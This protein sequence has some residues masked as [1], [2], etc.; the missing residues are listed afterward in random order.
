MQLFFHGVSLFGLAAI[1][2]LTLYFFIWMSVRQALVLG[3]RF[4]RTGLRIHRPE[5]GPV[6]TVTILGSL[7]ALLMAFLFLGNPLWGLPASP[8]LALVSL[9]LVSFLAEEKRLRVEREALS[10]LHGLHGLTQGGVALPEAIRLLTDEREGAVGQTLGRGLQLLNSRGSLRTMIAFVR[11]QL[12]SGPLDACLVGLSL[13]YERGL[14][15]STFLSE[16]LPS[17]EAEAEMQ[18]RVKDL[19]RSVAAQAAFAAILPWV[20]IGVLFSFQPELLEEMR[21]GSV[22]VLG[23]GAF[24]WMGLGVARLWKTS[25]FF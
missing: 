5:I 25:E 18:R 10:F 11:S 19:R 12:G 15:V 9:P 21:S 13:A 3:L 7:L 2:A 20:L 17:L 24:L 8:V 1:G 14:S 6:Y 4:L 22:G 16:A 23:L